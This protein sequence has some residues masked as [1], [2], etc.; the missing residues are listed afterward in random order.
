MDHE[1]GIAASRIDPVCGMIGSIERHGHWFCSAACIAAFE[2]GAASGHGLAR[3]LRDP[4]VWVP[5]SGVVLATAGWWWAAASPVSALYRSYVH[6]VI[7]PYLLGLLLGGIIEHFVPHEYIVKL[8]SGS[9]KRVIARSTVLGFLASTCS[10]GCLA[11]S[12]ELYRKGASTP[13]VISFLLASPWA[14]MSLT[15]IL[16]SLFGPPALAII[17]GALGIAFATGIIFQQ[18]TERGLVEANPKTRSIAPDFSI[19][20]DMARRWRD[21]AWT[22]THLK[23]D[24][25]GVIQGMLPLG[26]MM[27]GWVQLGLI[28][29]AVIGTFVPHDAFQ[30]FLSPTAGGLLITILVA[31]VI[32]VCS[33]GTAPLAF[34]FYRHTGELG[35]AFA[36]LMAGVV[37]DYTE[38]AVVWKA[39]GRRTALWMIA[40]TLPMVFVLGMAFN[41]LRW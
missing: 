13:A 26:R 28:L 31:S 33:E 1:D 27:M 2:R 24:A 6:K 7:G 12:I 35:N 11:L 8:L 41:F 18:L 15:F 10:H 32:E 5:V 36:F 37:T 23:E 21:H 22:R 34:E 39:I 3:W 25:A 17:L 14:S 30:R 20:Q 9:R 40:V 16:F 29:S 38:L 19:R 4:W